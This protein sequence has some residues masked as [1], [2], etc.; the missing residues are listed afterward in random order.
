M[1][2]LLLKGLS[3]MPFKPPSMPKMG[4]LNPLLRQVDRWMLRHLWIPAGILILTAAV[5]FAIQQ[6]H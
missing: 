5:S 2:Y 6:I 4:N 1:A 3:T